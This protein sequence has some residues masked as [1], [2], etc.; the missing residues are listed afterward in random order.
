MINRSHWAF[1]APA[2]RL[3][4][5]PPLQNPNVTEEPRFAKSKIEKISN[6]TTV[7]AKKIFS[8]YLTNRTNQSKDNLWTLKSSITVLTMV[9]SWLHHSCIPIS[10]MVD[11]NRYSDTYTPS[12]ASILS[13]VFRNRD[14]MVS[15]ANGLPT[16]TTRL[17]LSNKSVW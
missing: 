10:F 12:W 13:S 14:H 2:S 15:L 9:S 8:I 16:S 5:L 11:G 6:L 1:S 3:L 4:H 17:S 7:I